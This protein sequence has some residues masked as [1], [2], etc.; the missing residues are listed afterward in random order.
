[1]KGV[2]VL[3]IEIVGLGASDLEQMPLHIYRKL[4]NATGL[5]LRTQEHPAAKQLMNE[6]VSFTT[7]DH[8]YEQYDHFDETYE[9]IVSELLK[10]AEL[11]TIIYA[12]PGHPLVAEK[13]VQL[14]LAEQEKGTVTLEIVGG[15]SFLDP[16]FTALQMDPIEGCQIVDATNVTSNELE[17]RHHLLFV[18]VYDQITASNVKLTLMERLPDDYEVVIVEAAGSVDEAIRAVPLYELDRDITLSQLRVVY[19]P[20]VTQDALRY[21]EFS[22]LREI[23]A[24]LR[25]PNGCPWDRKQTH[26]SLKKY[27]IEETEEVIEAIDENDSEHLVEEL[28][29][30]LLQVM[31]HSQIGEDNGLFSV[32]DVIRTLSEKMIRRHPHVFG[33]LKIENEEELKTVWNEI[34]RAEK[35]S[36]N[37]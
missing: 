30:V 21:G 37:V 22:K 1:M 7:F 36:D 9:A 32:D 3:K 12:V 33:D 11:K 18:Q 26:E 8:L 17:I 14:L 5:F 24:Y 4:T 20:P 2:A 27:L 13:T 6:G 25:G 35:N 34:K 31:L 23:I 16:I 28:G 15:Q 29:D 10:A 19:V